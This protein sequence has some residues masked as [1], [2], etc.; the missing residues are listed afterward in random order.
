MQ[1]A[2]TSNWE[3][4]MNKCFLYCF[5][6]VFFIS[7]SKQTQEDLPL[8]L[9]YYIIDLD[10]EKEEELSIS[11]MFKNAQTIILESGDDCVIG[12]IDDIQFFDGCIYI[13]DYRK[14]KSLFVFDMEGNFIQKIGSVGNGPGE[15][16]S[17]KDFTL[18]T[19]NRIL[20]LRDHSNRIHKYQLDG[21]YIH[22]I[23][24]PTLNSYVD[25]IQFYNGRLYVNCLEWE[26]SQNGYMLLEINPTDGKILSRSLPIKYNKGWD[27]SL[28][29]SHSRF[30][31]SRGNNPPRFNLMFMDYIVSIGKKIT[32][33][34]KLKSRHLTTEKDIESFRSKDGEPNNIL[35]ILNSKKIFNVH[36]F[37]E[38]DDFI[39]F[40]YGISPQSTFVV[41]Y[42]KKTGETKIA[43][44]LNNDLIFKRDRDGKMGNFMF[45][46]SKGAYDIL[47]TQDYEL[48]YA[49]QNNETIPTLD[50]LDKLM[51]L[52]GDNNPII[53][54]Y[55][56]K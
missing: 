14:A 54:F 5:S 7:C 44:R 31:M 45:S 43:N 17:P 25:F 1:I 16:T 26:K 29:V 28:S 35:N 3:N 40:R 2:W 46:D 34:V 48:L 49:I 52:N 19:D 53:F 51:K 9:D 33:Y 21:T 23:T 50:K 13:L 22:T 55:E 24:I 38:S 4:I 8:D 41:V 37:I 27:E 6:S 30:F 56:F 39:S 32:P 42:E 20:F 18:D 11:C 10:K 36:C 12:Q 15:Y 47:N